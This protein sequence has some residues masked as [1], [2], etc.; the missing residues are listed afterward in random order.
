MNVLL[1]NDDGIQSTALRAI[2]DALRK[3]G[4]EVLAVAPM[5]QQS[6]V[7][8]SLTVFEPL[9]SENISEDGFSGIGV[10]GT[11]TDCVKLALAEFMAIPPDIVISGINIGRNVGPDLFYSGTVGGAAEGAHA[12]LKS[13][14]VSRA[15]SEAGA[16]LPDVASHAACLAEKIAAGNGMEGRVINVNYP[17]VALAEA[18]GP[19]LCRQ[20]TAIWRNVYSRQ[21]DP[22]GWPYWWLVGEIDDDPASGET[23]LD[24]LE[25]GYI[26]VTPLKFE[27]TDEQSLAMLAEKAETMFENATQATRGAS[28]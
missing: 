27:F 5:R 7:S 11:P 10:H 9:R 2:Y 15:G 23:D 19:R 4:H 28:L 18:R 24:L 17:S 1:T 20:S 6:G 26:T 16:D 14:A 13:M 12:G 3:R 22:R 21:R 25:R 8:R